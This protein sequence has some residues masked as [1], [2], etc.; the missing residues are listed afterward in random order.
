MVFVMPGVA[1]EK[2]SAYCRK[3]GV[4]FF[5]WVPR[6][7]RAG[8]LSIGLEKGADGRAKIIIHA[9]SLSQERHQLSSRVVRLAEAIR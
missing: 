3:H 8:L 5:S 9:K 6:P 4:L 2:V 7:V 1:A